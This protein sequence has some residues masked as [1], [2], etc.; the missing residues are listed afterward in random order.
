VSREL[1]VAVN[2][3]KRYLRF[4]EISYQI[5]LL[6]PLLPSVSTRMI[7]AP[8]LYWT[9]TGLARLL[10]E[11]KSLEDGPIYETAV[12]HE[13]LK[14]SSW[15]ADPPALHFFRT[16]TGWE[17]DFVM[18]SSRAFLAIE[19]KA[20]AK[21]HRQDARSIMALLDKV[22]LPAMDKDAIR[23]GLVVTRGRE[24][25]PLSSQ[26]W[27]IPFWQLFAPAA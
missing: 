12:L 6:R 23:L 20:G 2:T 9:D 4:L 13:L 24:V 15:Q 7:K 25:E 17:V 19:A 10:S 11:R 3:V 16:R 26:V 21:A 27:A 14:W 18:H 1:G 5:R 8:K 22:H